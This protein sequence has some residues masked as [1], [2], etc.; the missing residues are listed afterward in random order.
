MWQQKNDKI[1]V[2]R[3]ACLCILLI[4]GAL[5]AAAAPSEPASPAKEALRS[6]LR[7]LKETRVPADSLSRELTGD[8]MA[9]ATGDRR[10][11]RADV[12]AF[13]S[14]LT[15][16][17]VAVWHAQPAPNTPWRVADLSRQT[18]EIDTT[19]WLQQCLVDIM[20]GAGPTN[21]D[22]AER[23]RRVL[24]QLQVNDA[25]ANL[26]I[27]R[28]IAVGES[29]RGIRRLAPVANKAGGSKVDLHRVVP[30]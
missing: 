27:R 25:E 17:L 29:V 4:R 12:A 26:L 15:R 30:L 9:L 5:S 1:W 22:I 14:E 19:A 6:T 23:L 16:T 13:S 20:H 21:L 18:T 7:A 8:M 10:P 28:F 3:K 11:S 2:M 24:T